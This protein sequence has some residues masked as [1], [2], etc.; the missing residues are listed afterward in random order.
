MSE[1]ILSS[2]DLVD[3]KQR[4][5]QTLADADQPLSTNKVA[6]RVG[7]HWKS[8]D[9]DLHELLEAGRVKKQALGNRLTLWW[10]REIPL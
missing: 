3:R 10:D 1:N 6:D 8:V 2:G 9:K 4:I 7:H 5:L